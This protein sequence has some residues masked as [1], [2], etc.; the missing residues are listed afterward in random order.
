MSFVGLATTTTTIKST[1]ATTTTIK[2]ETNAAASPDSVV[3]DWTSCQTFYLLRTIRSVFSQI[4]K[5]A[6][7]DIVLMTPVKPTTN[8]T[9][10]ITGLQTETEPPFK[11]LANAF[12]KSSSESASASSSSSSYS[13]S[14]SSPS[15]P[16][17]IILSSAT[18]VRYRRHCCRSWFTRHHHHHHHHHNR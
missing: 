4:V 10:S 11:L 3:L 6:F 8:S 2:R 18:S 5:S 15:L 14:P 1:I 16:S 9:N 12:L 17:T 7:Y 13:S